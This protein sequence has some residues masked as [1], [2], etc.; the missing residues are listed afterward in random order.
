M[1]ED[2][3]QKLTLLATIIALE[4]VKN[5][6]HEEVCDLRFVISQILSTINTISGLNKDFKK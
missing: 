1:T 4:L 6:T 5:K 2:C 3:A